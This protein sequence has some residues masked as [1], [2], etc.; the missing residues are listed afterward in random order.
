MRLRIS[1]TLVMMFC[2][3][4]V[5]CSMHP[6]VDDRT[7]LSTSAIALK[8]R[9]EARDAIGPYAARYDL[10]LKKQAFDKSKARLKARLD[11]IKAEFSQLGARLRSGDIQR[12]DYENKKWGLARDVIKAQN[13]H[14]PQANAYF[15][16]AKQ[17]IAYDFR[18]TI[19]EKNDAGA[20]ASIVWPIHF[21]TAK[22]GGGASESKSRLSDRHVKFGET[23]E[24]LL[25]LDTC[26]DAEFEKSL[27]YPIKGHI[28][29]DETIEQYMVLREAKKL[30]TDKETYT[31]NLKF[32]TE[33][34]GDANASV[35]LNPSRARVISAGLTTAASRKDIHDVTIQ[36][37]NYPAADPAPLPEFVPAQ[38]I[39]V[40]LLEDGPRAKDVPGD[41][42][43]HTFRDLGT[44]EGK[45]R[46]PLRQSRDFATEPAD[47]FIDRTLGTYAR[48][49]SDKEL[50]NRALRE[51]DNQK[52][53][54]ADRDLR[55][56]LQDR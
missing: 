19:T 4:I 43:P 12:Y 56:F 14:L 37:T 27:R 7:G 41:G 2:P 55:E 13:K 3:G 42:G 23:I 44:D 8:V 15:T 32:T 48:P 34:A 20:S 22:I 24:E 47:A 31:D 9:C 53:L 35:T 21:G 40:R 16:F 51:L 49:P 26:T 39:E 11:E 10:K 52:R 38:L 46:R 45:E 50:I 5:A 18:F 1:V 28:G 6:L 25:A 17:V 33:I 29:L 36:L 30:N 54:D